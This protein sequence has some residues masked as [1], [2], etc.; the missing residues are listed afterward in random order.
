LTLFALSPLCLAAPVKRN[1][2]SAIG[3]EINN[4]VHSNATLSGIVSTIGQSISN[5][6]LTSG[7][8]PT[9]VLC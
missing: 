3:N 7:M 2:F 6:A 5:P 8:Y 1:F 9:L 4:I